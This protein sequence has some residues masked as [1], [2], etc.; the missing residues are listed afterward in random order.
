MLT[1]A[2][3]HKS[4]VLQVLF[5]GRSGNKEVIQIGVAEMKTTK[6]LVHKPLEGLGGIAQAKWHLYELK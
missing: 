3:K 5:W 1:K 2:L 6:N 4:H